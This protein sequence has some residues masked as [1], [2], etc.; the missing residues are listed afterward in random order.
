VP[1]ELSGELLLA[2]I[3]GVVHR[4]DPHDAAER[5][6]SGASRKRV[7][8]FEIGPA[9]ADETRIGLPGQE[10]HPHQK[11][12]RLLRS[13]QADKLAPEF[14]AGRGALHDDA[15]AVE[16]D[17]AVAGIEHDVREQFPDRGIAAAIQHFRQLDRN[18]HLL[19]SPEHHPSCSFINFI[20]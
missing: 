14:A 20:K 3:V 18:P 9:G 15:R 16:A 12:A 17:L 10:A 7:A 6:K 11:N 2:E 1:E 5:M 4:F 8:R 13:E 19:P